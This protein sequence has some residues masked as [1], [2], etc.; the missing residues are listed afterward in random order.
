MYKMNGWCRGY[1]VLDR[2]VQLRG[3]AGQVWSEG[4]KIGNRTE[5]HEV[6]RGT[7]EVDCLKPFRRVVQN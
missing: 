1:V 6:L 7:R 2:T 3:K 5:V 4:G